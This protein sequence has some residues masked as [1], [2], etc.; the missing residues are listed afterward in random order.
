MLRSNGLTPPDWVAVMSHD[1]ANQVE[2]Y[3]IGN[4]WCLD[5]EGTAERGYDQLKERYPQRHVLPFA[6]DIGSDDIACFV[7]SDPESN[8]PIVVIHD[9]APP[10][11][12][13]RERYD[14]FEEWVDAVRSRAEGQDCD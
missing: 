10:Q 3:Q 5:D 14:S 13:V 11:I 2:D 6:R 7:L 9:Y 8:A 1:G 12:A 4:W